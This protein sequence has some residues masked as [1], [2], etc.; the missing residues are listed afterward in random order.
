LLE[1]VFK[2]NSIS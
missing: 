2:P 1:I